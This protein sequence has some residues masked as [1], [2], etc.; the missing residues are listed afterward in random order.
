MKFIVYFA[1][2]I[3]DISYIYQCNFIPIRVHSGSAVL[4]LS[5]GRADSGFSA[6]A[7][8]GCSITWLGKAKNLLSRKNSPLYKLLGKW[9]QTL[10]YTIN[11]G[12]HF[13]GQAVAS[14]VLFMRL[15]N[16]SHCSSRTFEL[17]FILESLIILYTVRPY[18]RN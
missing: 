6:K 5:L 8:L 4:Q 15:K 7:L 10:G 14:L 9:I 13:G 16:N 2:Y 1:L 18:A 3:S 12:E 17:Y 11:F